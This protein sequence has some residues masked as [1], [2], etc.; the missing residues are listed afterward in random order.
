MTKI[1]NPDRTLI[2]SIDLELWAIAV[3]NQEPPE[4][5]PD[6]LPGLDLGGDRD[7]FCDEHDI[8]IE[9]SDEV[10]EFL[11]QDLFEAF[12][13][14]RYSA[15]A[16]AIEASTDVLFSDTDPKKWNPFVASFESPAMSI[17]D[18]FP[19]IDYEFSEG[20]I[21]FYGSFAPIAARMVAALEGRYQ[22]SNLSEFMDWFCPHDDAKDNLKSNIHLFGYYAHYSGF[23]SSDV[24][25]LLN[26]TV[27]SS[28]EACRVEF[29]EYFSTAS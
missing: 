20:Q 7:D 13:H 5:V 10:T 17:P 1:T 16:D 27:E 3:F 21:K 18:N 9:F 23:D 26:W 22:F 19:E 8:A 6:S 29:P 25:R 11:T 15:W 2:A 28:L 14:A 24:D 4:D 12:E